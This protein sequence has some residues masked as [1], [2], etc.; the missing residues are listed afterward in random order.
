MAKDNILKQRQ[1]K[2]TF[3][4][5]WM[6]ELSNFQIVG[7]SINEFLQLGVTLKLEINHDDL[8]IED[9]FRNEKSTSKKRQHQK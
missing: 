9:N 4:M 8:K 3:K 5:I 2:P 1:L 6:G 7:H